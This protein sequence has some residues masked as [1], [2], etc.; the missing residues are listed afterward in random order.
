MIDEEPI[1]ALDARLKEAGIESL[2]ATQEEADVVDNLLAE[3]LAKL[4]VEEQDILTF[5]V[6]GLAPEIEETE[7]LIQAS[8]DEMERE[9]QKIK[10]KPAYE[11]ALKLNQHHV[12]SRDFRIRFLRCEYFKPKIAAKRLILHFEKKKMMF[13][14]GE[15]L[16]RDV[17]VS[18]FSSTDLEY[19]KSGVLQVLPTRDISGR[20]GNL[21]LN[22]RHA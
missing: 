12:C 4:S 5:D 8:L 13:G 19:L 3:E 15:V 11:K 1:E 9:I 6:H 18:D 7:E 2:P 21:H 16:G 22:S 14:D 10:K 17:K 20:S